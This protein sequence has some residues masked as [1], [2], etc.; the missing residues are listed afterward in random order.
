MKKLLPILLLPVQVLAQPQENYQQLYIAEKVKQQ[1]YQQ[2]LDV[3]NT[4]DYTNATQYLYEDQ[5]HN[6]PFQDGIIGKEH[7]TLLSARYQYLSDSFKGL[8]TKV[9][10]TNKENEK[11]SEAVSRLTTTV[12]NLSTYINNHVDHVNSSVEYYRYQYPVRPTVI[13]NVH[14]SIRYNGNALKPTLSSVHSFLDSIWLQRVSING[15]PVRDIQ[16]TNFGE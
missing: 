10:E 16:F 15:S 1:Y 4:I 2:Q 6:V 9:S 3:L 11:S 7:F 8:K 12:N 5:E 14:T 13:N